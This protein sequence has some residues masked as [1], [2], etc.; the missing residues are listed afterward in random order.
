MGPT[1]P[2]PNPSSSPLKP[3]NPL[4]PLITTF[5]SDHRPFTGTSSPII[6]FTVIFTHKHRTLFT[7]TSSPIG[8]VSV[9]DDVIVS[10]EEKLLKKRS[11]LSYKSLFG[12]RRC[13]SGFFLRRRKFRVF[14]W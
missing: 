12:R 1:P 4:L 9:T 11:N 7:G 10:R 5:H 14:C 8:K 6:V 3:A 2:L 13:G